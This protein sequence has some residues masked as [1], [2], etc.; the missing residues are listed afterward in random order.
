MDRASAAP[1]AV[2]IDDAVISLD[3]ATPLGSRAIV[4]LSPKVVVRL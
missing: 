3:Q 2:S 4:D 1:P